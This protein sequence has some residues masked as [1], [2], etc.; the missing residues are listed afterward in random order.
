MFLL[1]FSYLTSLGV[2]P[3]FTIQ[4]VSIKFWNRQT[5][6]LF[7]QEFTIQNVSIKYEIIKLMKEIL[8]KFTI[9]NVSIK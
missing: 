2:N 4:N 1:N 7:S 9:Q 5:T 3:K 8:N 6:F